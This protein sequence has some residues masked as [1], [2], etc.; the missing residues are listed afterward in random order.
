MDAQTGREMEGR[1][2]VFVSRVDA[3]ARG[4]EQADCI[5]SP[6]SEGSLPVAL[7]ARAPHLSV[8]RCSLPPVSVLA[9]KSCAED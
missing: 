2:V 3:R 4:K 1:F 8:D 5:S 6:T 9:R 7:P